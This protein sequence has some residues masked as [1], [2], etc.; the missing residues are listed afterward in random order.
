MATAKKKAAPNAKPASDATAQ[1]EDHAEAAFSTINTFAEQARGQFET[2]FG[3]FSENADVAREQGEEALAAMR[4]TFEV[5]AEKAQNAS[6]EAA[7]LVREDI[8]GAVDFA[9]QLASA[10]SIP[11]AL[12][13]QRTYWNGVF[14][15][16]LLRTKKATET[17]VDAARDSAEPVNKTVGA[18]AA[19]T[20]SMTAFFPFSAK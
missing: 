15:T 18:F 14:E 3:A 2:A 11:A 19:M 17:F 12:E 8:A 20:P 4:Q 5:T 6:A 13:I 16:N 10:T 9:Q 1:F 7:G